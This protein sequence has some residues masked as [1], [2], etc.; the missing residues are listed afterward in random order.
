MHHKA[1]LRW[2]DLR[3]AVVVT[4]EVKAVRRDRA[5]KVLQRRERHA[6]SGDRTVGADA[7]RGV[8]LVRRRLSV[9]RKGL[10]RHMQPR[11]IP[12]GLRRLYAGW[13]RDSRQRRAVLQEPAPVEPAFANARLIGG[14]VRF[15]CHGIRYRNRV[16]TPV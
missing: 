7:P 2:I 1:V 12:A 5:V 16:S 8:T 14:V 9:S 6:V 3:H 15:S 4:L 11:Q 10:S 13:R